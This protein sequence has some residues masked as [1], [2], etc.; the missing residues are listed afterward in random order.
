VFSPYLL[1]LAPLKITQTLCDTNVLVCQDAT[2]CV[3]CETLSQ[4]QITW[5]VARLVHFRNTCINC[6]HFYHKAFQWCRGDE[7]V[8]AQDVG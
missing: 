4:A 1:Y 7:H 5:Y 6:F 3:A 2:L 8:Q